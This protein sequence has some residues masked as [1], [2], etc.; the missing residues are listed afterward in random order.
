M[1]D[2][3][4]GFISAMAVV[5]IINSFTKFICAAF[6]HFESLI[7]YR[8]VKTVEAMEAKQNTAKHI[9]G[10][11]VSDE[12]ESSEEDDETTEEGKKWKK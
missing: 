10:F 8:T 4:I 1:V 5:P 3:I 11:A 9:I 12:E 6:N 2:F 7:D